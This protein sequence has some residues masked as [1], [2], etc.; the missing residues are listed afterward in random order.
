MVFQ[1]E[2]QTQTGASPEVLGFHHQ[3]QN[4]GFL[5]EFP[6]AEGNQGTTVERLSGSSQD[7]LVTCPFTF[8]V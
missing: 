7:C 8:R 1:T 2:D 5:T 4:P 3:A 6:M